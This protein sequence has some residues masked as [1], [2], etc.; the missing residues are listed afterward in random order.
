MT[1]PPGTGVGD[2]RPARIKDVAAAAGVSLKTV[3]NVVHGRRNV[4]QETRQRVLAAISDLAYRPHPAGRQLRQGRTNM[5]TLV[6]PEITSPYFAQLSHLTIDAAREFGYAVFLEETGG[7]PRV[8]QDLLSTLAMR[9]FDGVIFSPLTASAES[10]SAFGRTVPAVFLGEHIDGGGLDHL[11]YD[12]VESV[13][14]A[15]RHLIETGRRRIAFLGTQP[16]SLNHT[17]EYRFTGYRSALIDAGMP[18]A[19][20]LAIR[21]T[22]Y[23]R[24]E[25]SARIAEALRRGVE[26]DGLICANDT[27]A[28]GAMH[29]LRQ[30]GRSVPGD[31]AVVGWDNIPEGRFSSPSLTTVAPD[32]DEL[33]RTAARVLIR[34][35]ENPGAS[36]ERHIIGH[37]LLVRESSAPAGG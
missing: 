15:T 8:E 19:R 21:A 10:L 13:K 17:G 32:V 30:A 25:G 6:V 28:I 18:A 1:L 29:A 27:L 24:E 34:R 35:I 23:S 16:G 12:N 14:E 7:D 22:D 37:R 31:V 4:G 9:V 2:H 36:A 26:F 11:A 5:L 33:A 20:R 3:S